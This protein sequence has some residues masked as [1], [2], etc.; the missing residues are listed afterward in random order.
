MFLYGKTLRDYA[1]FTR[2][3]MKGFTGYG[4]AALLGILI[5]A[6]MTLLVIYGIALTTSLGIAN[7][8][9]APGEGFQPPG[10][11][12]AQHIWGHLRF[13]VV[14]MIALALLSGI[15]FGLNKRR[16]RSPIAQGA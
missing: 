7:Y 4:Q 14:A 6:A 15:G 1:A 13:S 5:A 12:T 9:H 8:F 2:T 16:A 11:S 3:G 10:M